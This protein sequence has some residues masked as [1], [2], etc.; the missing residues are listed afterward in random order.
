MKPF[1]FLCAFALALLLAATVAAKKDDA[2]SECVEYV[3]PVGAIGTTGTWS[4][5]ANI[6]NK[7]CVPIHVAG[8]RG[9]NPNNNTQ[10]SLANGVY[11]RVKQAFVNMLYNAASAGATPQDCAE[12]V[13]YVIDMVSI[14][15]VVNQVQAELWGTPTAENPLPYP[16]RTILQLTG[17]N[18]LTCQYAT[19]PRYRQGTAGANGQV[20][21]AD[22]GTPI[23]DILE[24][25][26]TFYVRA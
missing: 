4:I 18:G 20:V 11:A 12:V 23:G 10:V 1:A 17:F 13:V 24:V 14:R 5:Q 21:C 2:A 3:N 7:R 15:P 16:P 19:E 9:I 22:D 26:G 6:K 8:M 25:K